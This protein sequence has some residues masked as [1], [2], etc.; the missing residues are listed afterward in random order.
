MM[1][2]M[3]VPSSLQKMILLCFPMISTISFFLHK[4]PIS[5]RCSSSNSRIR[6]SPGWVME[7]ILALPICFLKSIQK[8]GAV[9]GLGLLFSVR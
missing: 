7:R 6:S 2:S 4:S 1:L 8:L 9:R 3:I 5:S